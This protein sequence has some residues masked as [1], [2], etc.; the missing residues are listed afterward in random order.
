MI[1]I[2]WRR[3]RSYHN[4]SSYDIDLVVSGHTHG[5]QVRLPFIGSLAVPSQG[6]FPKYDAGE[7]SNGNTKMIISRGIGN[8]MVPLRINNPPEVVLIELKK[9]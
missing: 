1:N 7:Y 2:T 4:N 8:S 3:N 6:F 5:G 9:P